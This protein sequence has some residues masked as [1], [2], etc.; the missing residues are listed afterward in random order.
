MT[1]DEEIIYLNVCDC[2]DDY[3]KRMKAIAKKAFEAH[4]VDCEGRNPMY[5]GLSNDVAAASMRWALIQLLPF[6]DNKE[7]VI[8]LC[9]KMERNFRTPEEEAKWL[10]KLLKGL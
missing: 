5:I 4:A 2:I 6:V 7:H 3:A 9:D 1:E 10:D 8:A